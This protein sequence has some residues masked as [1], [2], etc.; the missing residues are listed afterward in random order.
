MHRP[1]RAPFRLAHVRG[2]AVADAPAAVTLAEARYISQTPPRLSAPAMKLPELRTQQTVLRSGHA[3]VSL[4]VSES[5]TL[6]E[7]TRCMIRRSPRAAEPPAA[8]GRPYLPSS[9][10]PINST[11]QLL[12]SSKLLSSDGPTT[13][14]P[15]KDVAEDKTESCLSHVSAVESLL[16][17]Q[18]YVD[19]YFVVSSL[20]TT[21]N[22]AAKVVES[23]ERRR[24]RL[25]SYRCLCSYALIRF[26]ECCE[27]GRAALALY[28][29]LQDKKSSPSLEMSDERLHSRVVQALLGALIMREMYNDVEELRLIVPP[30]MDTSSEPTSNEFFHIP[31]PPLLEAQESAIPFLASFRRHVA[32]QR[33]SDAAQTIDGS[34]TAQSWVKA[35]PLCAMFAFVRLELHDPKAAR[36]LLLP[37]LASLPEPPSW[38]ALSTAPVEH[39]QLW[40]H[41]SSHYVFSTTLLAKAS[42][43]SGSAYLNISAALLQRVLRLNP[44]YAPARLFA[45]FVLSYEA[46]QQRIDA[47]MSANDYPKVLSVTAEMLRMPEV[48]RLVH[49]ELYLMRTQAQWMRRQPLEV[50]H[51]ASRCVQCDPKCALAFRLRADAFAMMNREAEATA[52]RAVA[53]HLH[54]K[55]DAVFDELRVQRSRYDTTQVEASAKRHSVPAFTSFQSASAPPRAPPRK[56]FCSSTRRSDA[57]SQKCANADLL[58]PGL[59]THYE[60]LGVSSDAPEVEIRK[61]YRQ[62]TLQCHPDRFVGATEINRRAALEAFQLLGDAYSV[63]SDVQLRA[64]YDVGLLSLH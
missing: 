44:S 48:T 38:E 19:V 64:A 60:V 40:S 63:L 56:R 11:A 20:L 12:N 3:D 54:S 24:L 33:W 4:Y 53:M 18:Q 62:L 22:G 55:V 35:T 7:D 32:A 52:D 57:K 1:T 45:E 43:M 50:V 47:A 23:E 46:Q 13:L 5:T 26:K 49:A 8:K 16:S 31:P 51:E 36:A 27:D 14:M 61:R 30:L 41:F 29:H 10:E 2:S 6:T 15:H 58:L 39:A 28:R 9:L 17:R 21:D 37:Y 59:R 34:A 25:L 42:F